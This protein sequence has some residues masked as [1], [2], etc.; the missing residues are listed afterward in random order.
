MI[1]FILLVTLF[2]ALAW[3]LLVPLWHFP[4]EQAHFGHVAYLAEGGTLPM[5]RTNDLNQEIAIAEQRLGTYRNKYG[6][7]DFT[8]R[9]EYRLE[10]TDSYT[11][12]YEEEIK[13]LPL[14]S[15]KGMT[16]SRRPSISTTTIIIISINS[17]VPKPL[18]AAVGAGWA[19]G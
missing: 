18:D 3:S 2:K 5:G 12:R 1:K 9:P 6:N 11:G 7:N 17:A 13:A 19:W 14:A 4:D 8:Y 15:R 16:R 10:Y